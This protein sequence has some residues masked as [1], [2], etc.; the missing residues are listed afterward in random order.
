MSR[1]T[2]EKKLGLK[3]ATSKTPL[4]MT[5]LRSGPSAGKVSTD[6]AES[7]VEPK[8][9]GEAFVRSAAAAKLPAVAATIA[10]KNWVN[11]K[12]DE[13]DDD[14]DDENGF[15]TNTVKRVST[16]ERLQGPSSLSS[17]AKKFQTQEESISPDASTAA[18]GRNKQH[19]S[20]TTGSSQNDEESD[21]DDSVS[22]D[23]RKVIRKIFNN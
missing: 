1:A 15:L 16:T 23:I 6:S 14:D 3:G 5:L 7:P 20:S 2:L 22:A 21:S 10:R 13:D 12:D 11:T 8:S 17:L 4:L 19:L 9:G 18:G